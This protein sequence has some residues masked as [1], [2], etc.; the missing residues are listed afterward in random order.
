MH[1]RIFIALNISDNLKSEIDKWKEKFKKNFTVTFNK[2]RW[3]KNENLHITLIPPFYASE[4]DF[5]NLIEVIEEVVSRF[6]SFDINFYNISYGPNLFNPRLIWITANATKEI[7][8]LKDA[9]IDNMAKLG[10]LKKSD[11]RLRRDFLP[12]LTI[13]RF[14][15]FDFKYFNVKKIDEEFEF[16][17]RLNEVILF[18]SILK[19]EGAEYKILKK[20][21]LKK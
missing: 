17:E 9:L 19:K 5:Q 7:F 18:E 3:I 15:Q 10:F 2:I 12:H 20:F 6:S 8:I 14:N 1:H 13:A 21:N 11:L 16:K 4:T